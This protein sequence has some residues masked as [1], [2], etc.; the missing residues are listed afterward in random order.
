MTD[1]NGSPDQQGQDLIVRVGG[2]T[3]EASS[4]EQRSDDGTINQEVLAS[5]SAQDAPDGGIATEPSRIAQNTEQQSEALPTD[6][7]SEAIEANSGDSTQADPRNVESQ[8]A[9]STP[10][11]E[12][13]QTETAAAEGSPEE[14]VAADGEQPT[15]K[16]K[17]RKK[18]KHPSETG[19]TEESVAEDESKK[20]KH[21]DTFVAPFARFLSAAV[22]GKKHVFAVNEVVAGRVIRCAEGAVIVDLFGKAIA[23][24]DELEPRDI[25]VQEIPVVSNTAA[26]ENVKAPETETVP[27]ESADSELK[28][29][30]ATITQTDAQAQSVTG[31]QPSAVNEIATQPLSL[32][33]ATALESAEQPVESSGNEAELAAP[34]ADDESHQMAE[35]SEE[36]SED[37][38]DADSEESGVEAVAADLPPLEPLKIGQIFKGRIGAVAESGHVALI[39]RIVDIETARGRIEA[40]R[41]QRK[42]VAGLVFGF[43][44]GGFDV[45]IEGIRAFC[46][47]SGMSLEPIENPKD[48]IGKKIEFTIPALRGSSKDLIISRRSI[49]EKEHR[50]KI[51]ELIRSLKSGQKCKGKV[52]QVR[53]YGLFV[54]IGGVEGLVHQ[55]ELSYAFGVKPHDAAQVGDEV[56]V[57][58]IR[59]ST[60]TDSKKESRKDRTTRV[61]LSIKALLPDPWDTHRDA[62]AEGSVQHGKVIRTTDFGAFVELAPSV[63]GL[64]HISELGKELKHANQ[65]LKDGDEIYVVVERVDRRARR[66]SLSKLSES[67]VAD[68]KEG[69]LIEPGERP[70]S[71]QPG[72]R[73][74]VKVDGFEQRGLI[75]RVL[76]AAGKRGRGFIPNNETGTERGTDLRKKFPTST[77][78]EVKII[79]VER[80]GGIKCSI[81]AVAIDDERRAI[82]EYRREASKQGFGTF[83]D[84]LRAKLGEVSRE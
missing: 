75:V 62:V 73:V 19:S 56:D 70:V 14:A 9:P 49:L 5:S 84:L 28:A 76:G 2:D 59:I 52:T 39:N 22:S 29:S 40:L 24:V 60:P 15:K 18:R 10:G 38:E 35:S 55:S 7:G 67:A 32:D 57:E 12:S 78:L 44:R 42:R 51:K 27:S 71:L 53:D 4:P 50:K 34:H 80:D 58:I 61:D 17:R 23:V 45:I 30:D 36:D 72:A 74:K 66:I 43:N 83:G 81:K 64:L 77:A 48:H 20:A 8:R 33:S 68:F 31:D 3:S 26:D 79:G 21:K 47:A 46:P 6:S 41:E 37:E 13:E 25:P 1:H 63:E 65:V 82:K 11:E 16:R 69:K 54:D